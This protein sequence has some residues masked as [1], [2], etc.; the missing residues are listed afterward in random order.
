MPQARILWR[1]PRDPA[2]LQVIAMPV[3]ADGPDAFDLAPLARWATVAIGENGREHVVLSDGWRRIRFD[4]VQGSILGER[5]VKFRYLLSG[6][7]RAGP[8]LTTLNRLLALVRNGYFPKRYFPVDRAMARR[9]EALRTADALAAGAS[10]R[11]MAIALFGEQL[12]REEWNGRSDFL[13]SR[14]RRR[15]AEARRMSNGGWRELFA[16]GA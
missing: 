6:I 7:A 15:I 5:P 11:E 4:V 16:R 10:Q 9:V 13:K 3:E 1:S 8:Q 2:V 14:V 12:V